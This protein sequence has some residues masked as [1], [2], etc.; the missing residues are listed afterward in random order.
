MKPARG[1]FPPSANTVIFSTTWTPEQALAGLIDDLRDRVW[2]LY[3]GPIQ[4][5]IRQERESAASIAFSADPAGE[6]SRFDWRKR[7]QSAHTCRKSECV[8]VL[9]VFDFSRRTM[10]RLS[11]T[12]PISVSKA[13]AKALISIRRSRR[14]GL[15]MRID[16]CPM[17]KR[18]TGSGA[19]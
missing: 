5:L 19:T 13:V 2:T 11:P 6:N 14:V 7:C 16:D 9:L 8:R 3:A 17:P 12:V 4:P 10:P 15:P 1:Y 18:M